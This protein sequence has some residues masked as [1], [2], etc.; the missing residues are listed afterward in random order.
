MGP[1]GKKARKCRFF[2]REGFYIWEGR[3]LETMKTAVFRR[4]GVAIMHTIHY[5]ESKGTVRN[6]KL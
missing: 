3:R 2:G 5:W 4:F 6:R 1:G